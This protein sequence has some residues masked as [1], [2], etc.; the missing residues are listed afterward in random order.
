M[1]DDSAR[2]QAG[3]ILADRDQPIVRVAA[4]RTRAARPRH[5]VERG[6]VDRQARQLRPV[7]ETG[8]DVRPLLAGGGIGSE[9]LVLDVDVDDL[10]VGAVTEPPVN[11][12]AAASRAATRAVFAR[13]PYA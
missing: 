1:R 6:D 12:G 7:D 4:E 3:V 5:L 2:A 9:E 8:K 11:P 10:A 13:A